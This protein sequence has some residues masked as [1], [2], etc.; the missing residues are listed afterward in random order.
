MPVAQ[1]DAWPWTI[2][3]HCQ[4]Q[5]HTGKPGD[6]DWE[7]VMFGHCARWSHDVTYS[8][9]SNSHNNQRQSSNLQ[10]SYW[11]LREVKLFS[12]LKAVFGLLGQWQGWVRER[13]FFRGFEFRFQSDRLW[14][15]EPGHPGVV[16]TQG[17]NWVWWASPGQLADMCGQSVARLLAEQRGKSKPSSMKKGGGTRR[18]RAWG[19]ACG[20]YSL[21]VE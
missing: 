4:E 13:P 10:R 3:L 18:R 2:P 16:R 11:R 17:A 21:S 20:R 14:L 1:E 15:F 5:W 6:I 8:I 7:S 12:N 19:P 9:P